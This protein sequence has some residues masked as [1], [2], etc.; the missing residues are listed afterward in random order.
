L[1]GFY[2]FTVKYLKHK[3]FPVLIRIGLGSILLIGVGGGY[4]TLHEEDYSNVPYYYNKVA[5]FVE[6]DAKV[7]TLSQDYGNRI[8]FY[9]WLITKQWKSIGDTKYSQ[10]R[11]DEQEPFLERFEEYTAGYDYF[12]I[13]Q[14][15]QLE[16]QEELS[17]HLKDNFTVH[18]QDGGYIIYDLNLRK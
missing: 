7:V 18:E 14:L 1:A 10:L 12:I 2:A 6:R 8:A 5:N 13:T 11:G 15:N 16:K 9:G 4:Y 3:F 17:N